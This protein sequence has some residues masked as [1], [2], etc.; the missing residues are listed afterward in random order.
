MRGNAPLRAIVD[1]YVLYAGLMPRKYKFHRKA[2][3]T[4]LDRFED[5][6]RT[7][8]Q[9]YPYLLIGGI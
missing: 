9:H 2:L 1:K 6:V 4:F 7:V 8:I 3:L 5:R